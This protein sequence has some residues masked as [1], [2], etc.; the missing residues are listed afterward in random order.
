[1]IKA[2]GAHERTEYQGH[3]K[4]KLGGLGDLSVADASGTI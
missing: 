2:D 4:A 1:M 3:T